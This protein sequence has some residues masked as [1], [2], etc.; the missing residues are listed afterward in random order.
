M[1]NFP[2]S[3]CYKY[4]GY[5][6]PTVPVSAATCDTFEYDHIEFAVHKGGVVSSECIPNTAVPSDGTKCSDSSV[7][8][9]KYF[10]N[11]K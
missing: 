4:S 6:S 11:Y 10:E 9:K 3:E 5:E 8:F 1:T 2:T 7:K